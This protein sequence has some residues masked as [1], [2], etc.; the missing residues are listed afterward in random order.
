MLNFV[1]RIA[2]SASR[3]WICATEMGGKFNG[4]FW[5][6][7]WE[8]GHS[9][10]RGG[11]TAT[12]T[13]FRTLFERQVSGRGLRSPNDPLGVGCRTSA[14]PASRQKRTVSSRPTFGSF[15]R[16]LAPLLWNTTSDLA[17]AS[18]HSLVFPQSLPLSATGP[19]AFT[20]SMATQVRKLFTL[21]PSK[22]SSRVNAVYSSM[23]RTF[24]TKMKSVSPVT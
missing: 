11:S 2:Q 17:P 24:I 16:C 7:E 21:P 14:F 3:R 6:Q 18:R 22:N 12:R 9:C 1:D 20:F 19:L 15:H 5:A 23:S 10:E 8:K 4:G 13:Y